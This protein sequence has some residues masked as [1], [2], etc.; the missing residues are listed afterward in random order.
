MS[1]YT[2]DRSLSSAVH[3]V[4]RRSVS[5]NVAQRREYEQSSFKYIS[6]KG[7]AA[8]TAGLILRDK[9]RMENGHGEI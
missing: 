7:A 5:V 1:D 3:T 4:V 6:H 2:T 8:K 9:A